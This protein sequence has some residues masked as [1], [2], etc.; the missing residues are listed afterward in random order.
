M[1]ASYSKRCGC[2]DPETGKPLDSKC[3]ELTKRRHGTHGFTTRLD[4]TDRAA[5]QL[6][7]FGFATQTAAEQA[8]GRVRDL[9]QLARDDDT[10]RRKI[11]DL[12]F[13][14][15]HGQELPDVEEVRRKLKLGLDLTASVGTV[16]DLLE[17]WY[18]SKRAKKEST[19]RGWRQ[20]LDHYL[21]PQL[22]DISRDRLRAAHIDGMFDTI[23]EW[24]A[25][26]RTAA[27]EKRVPNLAGD[28]RERHKVTGV[29]T[30]HRIFAT[31]RNAYNWAVK[32][33]MV[34]SNPCMGVEL[35]AEER[36]PARVWSPEQ[37]GMFLEAAEHDP[38][39]LL[40]RIVLLRGLRRGE[41]CGLRWS[42]LDMDTGHA[43]ITQT[44]LQL[45]GRI[46][47]DTP[48]TRAGHRVVSLD[49]DTV[50]LLKAHHSVQ[51]RERFAAGDRY[52]DNDLVF[53]RPDG[54]PLPPDRVTERFKQIARDTGLPVI[55][56]HEARHTAASLGL[57][58]GLDVKIVS[59]QLGHSTT[60]ITRD[61]Y[62]H[63][64]QAVLDDA[65]EKV[66]ALLPGRKGAQE[67]SS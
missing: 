52:E 49:T 9:V 45:G 31:L 47:I 30:Q 15:K 6:K 56:L 33:R 53:P 1:K 34:E 21:I 19:R 41:A 4:T 42:D 60:T 62:Q 35:P 43:R 65:A 61:L 18:A 17:D 48:K 46:V 28:V 63:V 10:A 66:V 40:Y 51:R 44:V 38:L 64:R 26:I 57:E 7:R 11:G 2:K 16:A 39:G 3:P 67:A 37:V 25:E 23:E 22:G 36:D 50:S 13:A 8:F 24:N 58:A 32:R 55:K 12:I 14:T 54:R 5:R 20:H 27:A 29:A 59:A